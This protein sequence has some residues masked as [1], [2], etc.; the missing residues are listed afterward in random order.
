[1]SN[2]P[3]SPES[4]GIAQTV[5]K[6][7]FNIFSNSREETIRLYGH[8]SQLNWC[9]VEYIGLS[10]ISKFLKNYQPCTFQVNG[11]EVQSVSPSDEGFLWS[12]LVVVGTYSS[13]GN[14]LR[15]FHCTFYIQSNTENQHAVIRCQM[16]QLI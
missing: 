16:F 7:F 11:Y 4:L 13:I 2:D 1:M 5:V 9:G 12:M 10:E 14:V 8:H 15:D 6:N 3:Q